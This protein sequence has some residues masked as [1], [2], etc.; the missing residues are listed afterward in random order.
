MSSRAFSLSLGTL[1]SVDYSKLM[2][3]PLLKLAVT[4]TYIRMMQ[5]E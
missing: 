3:G 2:R 5:R 4:F 1:S